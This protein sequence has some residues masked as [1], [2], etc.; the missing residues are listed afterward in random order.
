MRLAGALARAEAW[1]VE[2]VEA[3]EEPRLT[4]AAGLR[5]VVAVFGLARG[6]G[7]TVVARALA[8]ELAGRDRDGAATVS[9]PDGASAPALASGAAGRL[10]KALD[11]VPGCSTRASGSLCLV[12]GADTLRLVDTAR[13]FAPLVLDEGGGP[14]GGVGASAADHLVLIG[15]P[16][17]DPALAAV[18]GA[19]L[20]RLGTEPIVVLNR[21][22]EPGGWESS[23]AVVLPESRLAARLALA[24]R[25]PPGDLGATIAELADLLGA[26]R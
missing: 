9:V 13:H 24:G 15:S 25:E 10:S 6:C 23:A 17:V 14:V 19:C 8:V 16:A 18:A 26:P 2:P 4:V 3:R 22:R 20:R 21:A 11:D 7:A 5:P 1:L 12:A